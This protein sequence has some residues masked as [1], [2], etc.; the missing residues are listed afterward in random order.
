[1]VGAHIVMACRNVKAANEIAHQ[2]RS[3]AHEY[4][5]TLHVE[6][7]IERNKLFLVQI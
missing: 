7:N 4:G 1:M 2:W 5:R 6:V 3:E